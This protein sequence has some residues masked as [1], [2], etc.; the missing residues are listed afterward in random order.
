MTGVALFIAV[1][2]LIAGALAILTLLARAN[3]DDR[4]MPPHW[5]REQWRDHERDHDR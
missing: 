4:M 5:R 2:V 1:I 3:D